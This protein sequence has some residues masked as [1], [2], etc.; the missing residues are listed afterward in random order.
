MLY[1]IAVL[2]RYEKLRNILA[3]KEKELSRTKIMWE[4]THLVELEKNLIFASDSIPW[5]TALTFCILA[6]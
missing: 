3:C 5:I 4:K 1:A 6:V 2:Q